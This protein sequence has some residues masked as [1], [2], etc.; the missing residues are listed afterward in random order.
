MAVDLQQLSQILE[1][2]LDP[3]RNKQGTLIGLRKDRAR[4]ANVLPS[5]A[6]HTPGGKKAQF[7]ALLT[8][9]SRLGRIQW[10]CSS[11]KRSLLQELRQAELDSEYDPKVGLL[12]F[13]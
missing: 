5:G 11:R 7:L 10:H 3:S 6:G 2:S 12:V 9:D 13:E 8:P 1:A 4:D